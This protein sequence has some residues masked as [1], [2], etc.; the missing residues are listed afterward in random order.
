MQNF[1][2]LASTQTDLDQ[3]LTIFEKKNLG[4]FRKTL[5][6]IPKN[7]KPEYA[8]QYL[9]Y[10]YT[11]FFASETIFSATKMQNQTFKPFALEEDLRKPYKL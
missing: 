3:F 5:K 2:S 4:F 7:S 8:I 11:F 6:R 9:T 10:T 1:S